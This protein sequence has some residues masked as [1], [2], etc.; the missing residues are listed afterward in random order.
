M[1]MA[2]ISPTITTITVANNNQQIKKMRHTR[3]YSS[4]KYILIVAI[5]VMV[6]IPGLQAQQ[7][8]SELLVGTWQFDDASSFAT[9]DPYLNDNSSLQAQVIA[10]YSGRQLSI[11]ADGTFVQ[12][13]ANGQSITCTWALSTEGALILT[14]ALGN[15]Y[16]NTLQTLTGTKL[17][18]VPKVG[19]GTR[20][21]IGEQHFTKQP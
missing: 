7:S 12:T 5:T 8:P 10:S 4:I 1:P 21:L 17:V 6:V 3:P 2:I 16:H 14:D 20:N 13:L 19:S 11:A 15:T 9:M 18:F